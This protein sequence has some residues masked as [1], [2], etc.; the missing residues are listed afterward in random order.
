M[1][2]SSLGG[3]RSSISQAVQVCKGSLHAA[4]TCPPHRHDAQEEGQ[5]HQWGGEGEAK[6]RSVRLT[7][8]PAPVKVEAKQKN[9]AEKD[10]SSDKKVQMKWKRGAK[11]KTG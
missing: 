8:K 11:G 5:F 2:P 9:A 10:K 4:C 6:G 1:G 3:G 7:A